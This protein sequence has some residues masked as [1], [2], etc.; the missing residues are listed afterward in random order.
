MQ[1]L[2][3]LQ[4][5]TK[6]LK[7]E[8]HVLMIAYKDKRTPVTAKILIAV[9]VGY[10]LSPID[11]VPDFIPVLGL[12]D[13]LIIVPILIAVSLKMIPTTVLTDAR[14]IAKTKQSVL[15]KNNR[16]AA[17]FIILVWLLLIYFTYRHFKR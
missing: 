10:L 12:L 13:D 7:Q 17:V 1:W 4:Q 8:A 15:K 11:L 14:A 9:T 3:Q 2:Q 5:K 6:R 16:T